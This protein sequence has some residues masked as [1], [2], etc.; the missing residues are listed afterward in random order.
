MKHK[1]VVAIFGLMILFVIPTASAQSIPDWIKNNAGWWAEGTIT[2][3]DFIL[4]IQFLLGAGI[5]SVHQTS[6]SDQQDQEIPDWIKNNAG[7]WAE[8]LIS[9]DDFINGIQYL[10]KIGLISVEQ[11][12]VQTLVGQFTDADFIH[13]T[14]GTATLVIEGDTRMLEFENF[15]TLGGPDLYVYL[16][17][18]KSASDFVNLGK[19][20]TFKGAQ[21]YEIAS[22]VDIEK[23]NNVLVWC[24]AFGVLFGSAE[25]S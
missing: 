19:L 13:R 11:A 9:D 10:I 1:S 22:S 7:W 21:S 6:A 5:L 18:D 25:L 23:Y 4:G 12:Q 24:Q 16:S 3:A 17:A 14:S 2:D 20:D 8:G 15:E